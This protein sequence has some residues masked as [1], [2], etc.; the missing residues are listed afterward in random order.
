MTPETTKI[1]DKL[2]A[3]YNRYMKGDDEVP[4]ASSLKEAISTIKELRG[5]LESKDKT[6]DLLYSEGNRITKTFSDALSKREEELKEA[7]KHISNLLGQ[8][9]NAGWESSYQENAS[10]FLGSE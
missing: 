6:M 1:E 4:L 2:S 8:L 3:I 10:K 7:K 9:S 5:S